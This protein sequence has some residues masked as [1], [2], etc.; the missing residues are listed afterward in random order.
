MTSLDLLSTEQVEDA[1][2]YNLDTYAARVS[3][4]QW[5]P[6]RWHVYLA[7][8][9]IA[10]ILQGGARII[11]TAP[12]RH[13]KSELASVWLP[14]W[15][16]DL[17]PEKRIITAS[18]SEPL[19]RKFS[20]RVRD[21]FDGR[22]E[23]TWTRIDPNHAQS[24]EW[25]TTQ[26]GGMRAAGVGGS[27]TGFGGDIILP[28]DPHKDWFEAQS[29]A[30]LAKVID[31]FNGTVYHRMEPNASIVLIQTRWNEGDLAGYLK[32]E[33]SD[34][35]VE[36]RLPALAEEDDPL[37][38]AIGEAL[39]PQRYDEVAL[40]L[41]RKAVGSQVF[42]GL[43]Q[44]RPGPAEGNIIKREW[45]QYYGGPTGI[46]LPESMRQWQSWD[47]NAGKKT[48]KGSYAC[49]QV[50]GQKGPDAYALDLVRDRWA[51]T[52]TKR[53][54]RRLCQLWPRAREKLVEDAAGG[55]PLIEDMKL[56]FSGIVPINP[57]NSKAA[58]M[59]AI[60]PAFES[61]HVWFPHP[62]IAPWV[63]DLVEEL[64]VFPNGEA[65][66]QGDTLSQALDRCKTRRTGKMDINLDIG[67]GIPAW[68]L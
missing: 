20:I 26:G 47:I 23:H 4:G 6:Y 31:W 30:A 63:S 33:H 17:F 18:Y 13:G 50:W 66:D 65:D 22:N 12:P 64:V 27:I 60:S 46:D 15:F 16:L 51:H 62:T 1:W 25:Y 52:E 35:W 2:R 61:G 29:P 53:Q 8:L 21:M 36:I 34:P 28:D 43:F 41:I 9:L 45:I 44:Q 37:G 58:R 57:R 32:R 48:K 39:C 49:G 54:F 11:I 14:A 5:I 68:R 59:E 67:A 19:V 55:S 24:T 10:A 42:A 7:E 40:D 38:R 56:E 3:Y